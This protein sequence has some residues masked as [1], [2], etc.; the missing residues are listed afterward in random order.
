[1]SYSFLLCSRATQLY[2][3]IHSFPYSFSITVYTDVKYSSLFSNSGTLFIRSVCNGLH[4]LTP[5]S[6]WQPAALCV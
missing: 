1:M 3:Y 5:D 2:L 4:L 6:P